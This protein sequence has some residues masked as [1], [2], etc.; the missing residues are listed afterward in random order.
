MPGY[1]TTRKQ[2]R[3]ALAADEPP[4]HICGQAIDY[5][6]PHTD[7]MSFQADHVTPRARGGSHT[8]DNSKA[9]HRRCNREKSDK[10]HQAIRY[11]TPRTW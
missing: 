3:K 4:C 7:P 10:V 6:L 11:V 2:I 1:S 9:S 8:L 5:T